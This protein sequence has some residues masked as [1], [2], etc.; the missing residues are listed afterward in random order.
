MRAR[1]RKIWGD[2]PRDDEEF[3][4]GRERQ[5]ARE[6]RTTDR[7]V[8]MGGCEPRGQMCLSLLCRGGLVPSGSQ[9]SCSQIPPRLTHQSAE[10]RSQGM[11]AVPRPR[12]GENLPSYWALGAKRLC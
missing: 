1:D 3:Q 11:E 5:S 6:M 4:N 9:S 7:H 2:K 12:R 8:T 10:P